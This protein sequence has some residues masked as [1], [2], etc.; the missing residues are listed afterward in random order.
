MIDREQRLIKPWVWQTVLIRGGIPSRCGMTSGIGLRIEKRVV[1]IGAGT[2]DDGIN[3]DFLIIDDDTGRCECIHTGNTDDSSIGEMTDE[4][5]IDYS[6][7]MVDRWSWEE[8]P[9]FFE[10]RPHL[11]D[12]TIDDPRGQSFGQPWG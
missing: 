3:L 2:K 12:L 1:K 5:V 10:R 11:A 9:F 6:W 4:V 8:M 7:G